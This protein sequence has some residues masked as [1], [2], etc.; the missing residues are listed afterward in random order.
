MA[1]HW[2]SI[3]KASWRIGFGISRMAMAIS[4]SA[5]DAD[6]GRSA[7]A[8]CSASLSGNSGT[9]QIDHTMVLIDRIAPMT[10]ATRTITGMPFASSTSFA[11][12]AVSRVGAM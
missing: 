9:R 10:K 12:N 3:A 1:Y 11:T 2:H 8:A 4:A 6:N 5:E 7:S